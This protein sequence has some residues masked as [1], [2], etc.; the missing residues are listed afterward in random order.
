MQNQPKTVKTSQ[1][2]SPT[3]RVGSKSQKDDFDYTRSTRQSNTHQNMMNVP[4]NEDSTIKSSIKTP[5]FIKLEQQIISLEQ[6][7]NSFEQVQEQIE[8]SLIAYL[9]T[10]STLSLIVLTI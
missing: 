3:P 1:N 10:I 6:N 9:T 7:L 2:R 8:R 5:S 4:Q